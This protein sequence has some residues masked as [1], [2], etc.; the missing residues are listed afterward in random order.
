LCHRLARGAK[1]IRDGK[2]TI[3]SGTF[4]GLAAQRLMRIFAKHGMVLPGEP[5]E[6]EKPEFRC[7]LRHPIC[8]PV[9]LAQR[10]MN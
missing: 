7:D 5:A 3:V 4:C 2:A 6:L 1:F 8:S 10:R 9:Q